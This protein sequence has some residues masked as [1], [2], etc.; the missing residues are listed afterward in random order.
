MTI[1]IERLIPIA[2]IISVIII[3]VL[4][5]CS[6]DPCYDR[7]SY[8]Q[9]EELPEID[10]KELTAAPSE[11]E[12]AAFLESINNLVLTPSSAEII[13]SMMIG[14]RRVLYV[15]SHIYNGDMHYSAIIKPE[16]GINQ[17]TYEGLLYLNGLDQQ[18]P[19]IDI[20]NNPPLRGMMRELKNFYLIV[21]SFR[22]QSLRLAGKVYCSDGDF[23]DAFYGAAVDGVVS[24]SAAKSFLPDLDYNQISCYGI[25][26]GATAGLIAAILKPDWKKIIA[27]SG[28]YN[29][30]HFDPPSRYNLQYKYQFLTHESD[31]KSRRR[32]IIK[33]SPFYFSKEI[34][35]P[36]YIIHGNQDEIA[37]V[38]HYE[39]L[40]KYHYKDSLWTFKLKNGGH[41]LN[42][43][44]QVT[45]WLKRN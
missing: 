19:T 45:N 2:R 30:L 40:Y 35:S 9:A 8:T 32:R 6:S 44:D 22:G 36:T 1:Y 11:K 26:R 4:C 14:S 28:P 7:I 27:Q 16:I 43:M 34:T 5:S 18:N 21:P 42:E 25:S 24:L 15:M 17:D 13:D 12:K 23:G 33:S 20:Y 29:F 3:I 31:L 41:I 39:S 37:P 10:I 38:F